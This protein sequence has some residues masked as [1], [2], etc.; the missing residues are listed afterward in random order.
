M[1]GDIQKAASLP[2]SSAKSDFHDLVDNA[3]IRSDKITNAMVNSSAAI[4]SSKLADFGSLSSL[5]QGDVLY[6]NGT[7]IVR[8]APGTSGFFLK[9]NG[10]DANPAWAEPSATGGGKDS[11][12]RGFEIG[13]AVA[14][15]TAITVTAG[16]LIHGTTQINKTAN[17]T[18]TFATAADWWD[19]AAD[20][21]SGGA[22]WCYVGVDVSGNIKLL[23]ANP[24]DKA[25]TAGNTAGFF[26]YWYDSSLYW[27]VIGAI[28][29]D[30]DDQVHVMG[31]RQY[32][33]FV[34][35]DEFQEA[36]GGGTA[37]SFTDVD[38][39]AFAPGHTR[40]LYLAADVGSVVMQI[41]AN[42][43]SATN[44]ATRIGASTRG[45][46]WAPSDS[47]QVIEYK[48]SGATSSDIEFA[49]Y[50]ISALRG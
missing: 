45:M 12:V 42:G 28:R 48:L 7:S 4:A 27:R 41:R 10:A 15:D 49:G 39:S 22:G 38:C 20:S 1:A 33:N 5:V 11:I 26:L 36:L 13:A 32:G 43:S 9:T 3:T 47:S 50:D 40:Q 24:A 8:L 37:T 46:M 30:T 44:G 19:G 18:L 31:R 29:V 35:L 2:D 14:D 17:T 34:M 25:D 16:T 6:H 23:G 21:Y